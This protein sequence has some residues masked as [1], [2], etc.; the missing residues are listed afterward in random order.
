MI[1]RKRNALASCLLARRQTVYSHRAIVVREH[2]HNVVEVRI[3]VLDAV[4]R[5]GIYYFVPNPLHLD[6]RRSARYVVSQARQRQSRI[7]IKCSAQLDGGKVALVLAT[8]ANISV[9][10]SSASCFKGQSGNVFPLLRGGIEAEDVV[11]ARIVEV[12]GLGC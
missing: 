9:A 1:H 10:R 2:G 3:F 4:N 7:D 6:R 11:S 5:N 12:V 8:H